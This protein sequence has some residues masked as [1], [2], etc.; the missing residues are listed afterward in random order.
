MRTPIDDFVR[1]YAAKST[2]RLHMPGHKGMGEIEQ[3]DITEIDGAVD[4]I[5]ESE[6]N[7]S[8]LFGSPTLYSAEGSSLAIRAMLYLASLHAA[9]HG[10]RMRVAAGRNAHKTFL[11]AVALLD[12]K[13]EWLLPE[14]EANYLSCPLTAA[15]VEHRLQDDPP[16]ALYLTTPDY[17]G[18]TVDVR[19]IAE[20][21]HRLGVLLLVDNAH[22]AYLRFLPESRHPIDLGA[23]LCCSSAHKTLP[24]L[25]G[26][27]YLHLSPTLPAMLRDQAK[28]ALE[29]FASTSPSYLIYASLDRANGYLAGDYRARLAAFCLEVDVL[30]TELS[31]VGFTLCGD[32]PLKLTVAT[33]GYGYTGTQLAEYL[34]FRGI[35]PEF[36]DPD[37]LVL[38][39]TPECDLTPIREALCSLPRRAPI[40]S[41]PS[42][43]GDLPVR[44]MSP[45]AAILSPCE[46]LPADECVGRIIA[47]LTVGCPPA[48]P[49]LASGERV[50]AHHLP[51][52]AYYGIT[53]L[54]VV[55]QSND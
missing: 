21:C 11:S 28:A 20:V 10:K 50:E 51:I 18:N 45:R 8:L 19:E 12:A 16:T 25:T 31:E 27:A 23:D 55:K 33:K 17:L 4:I 34:I 22:G 32:E 35:V 48:V 37:H 5:G 29:L 39:L 44:A 6:E 24:V 40:P 49:V 7:A 36:Y 2:A 41:H 43:L 26:G 30:K 38:M 54:R 1:A 42:V 14:A 13:V 53:E 46:C 47:S 9:S 15:E 3:F 52:F